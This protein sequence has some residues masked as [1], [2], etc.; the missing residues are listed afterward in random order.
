MHYSC[1]KFEIL[2][3][4]SVRLSYI[5]WK[6]FFSHSFVRLCLLFRRRRKLSETEKAPFNKR[7]HELREKHKNDHPDY[8][9]TPRRRSNKIEAAAAARAASTV[10]AASTVR[11]EKPPR[12]TKT[13]TK[14]A[15]P[16]KVSSANS[17]SSESPN[18]CSFASNDLLPHSAIFEQVPGIDYAAS[19]HSMNSGVYGP[20]NG[21]RHTSTFKMDRYDAD[22]YAVHQFENGQRQES[23]C[24]NASSNLSCTLTPPATPHNTA[25]L[26]SSSPSKNLLSRDQREQNYSP[27]VAPNMVTNNNQR[28]AM[29]QFANK[30]ASHDYCPNFSQPTT[31]S[32]FS[33][34]TDVSLTEQMQPFA[35]QHQFSDN[36]YNNFSQGVETFFGDEMNGTGMPSYH[37]LS[38]GGENCPMDEKKFNPEIGGRIINGSFM[39]YVPNESYIGYHMN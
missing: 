11:P 5:H 1:A 21:N 12:R 33:A 27:Y 35:H 9:Y 29:D 7:A 20:H 22:A 31:H 25:I 30:Y 4:F 37:N 38:A 39:P 2:N 34:H 32:I 36:S 28:P 23:P 13:T 26:G 15:P 14:R 8:K 24:S 6:H 3:S 16:A 10:A 19:H 17:N 18:S